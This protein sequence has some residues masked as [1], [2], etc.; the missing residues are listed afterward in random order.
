M[1]QK[2]NPT[3]LRIGITKD[4]ES[5]WF[6]K[7]GDISK[8]L[9]EDH[10]IRTLLMKKLK[11]AAVS[12][13]EIERIK[14]KIVLFIKTARPGMVLGKQGNDIK[15]LTIDIKK[16]VGR[17]KEIKIDI[18]EIEKPDWDAYLVGQ[19]IA[20]A[21]E[22]RV[23]FRTAQKL[24][25]KKSLKA[26]VKGI[27]TNVSG[28]LGGVEMAR[29]E[30]Y[31]EGIV[32]LSTLRADIDY[33]TVEAHTT[34]GLIGVKVWI[35]RGEKFK[36]E[37]Q[38]QQAAKPVMETKKF[39]NNRDGRDNRDNRDNRNRDFNRKNDFNRNSNFN[40]NS[41]SS[42]PATTGVESKNMGKGE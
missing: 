9:L 8:W 2:I 28:R 10:K 7:K 31:S 5:R 29:E 16:I 12:H 35:N 17:K 14:D 20:Q 30:G 37:K 32:P 36:S 18:V 11:D 19:S 15:T 38:K 34:Y 22:N 6:A 13:I 33:A 42:K 41:T 4:W 3:G 40:R 27:K 1:G 25:I 23:S 24:A 26:G 21:I 39:Y